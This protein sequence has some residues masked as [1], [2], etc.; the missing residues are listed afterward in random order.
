MKDPLALAIGLLLAALLGACEKDSGNTEPQAPRQNIEQVS[1]TKNNGSPVSGTV[2]ELPSN[3]CH[4]FGEGISIMNVAQAKELSGDF[5]GDG[6]T[7]EVLFLHL[8]DRP[9]FYEDVRIVDLSFG[10]EPTYPKEGSIGI[11][12]VL[13]GKDDKSCKKYIA[14]GDS[15]FSF[16]E[17]HNWWLQDDI[18]IDFIEKES[19]VFKYWK[20][21]INNLKYDALTLT[22][23][24]SGQVLI[25]WDGD[26]FK[27][28][29][30]K[31]YEP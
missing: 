9:Q 15:F 13:A 6:L 17:G 12:F 14:Y 11:A 10:A 29:A 30:D 3:K 27:L 25:Y 21:Q 26:T 4:E 19:D 5:N 24:S 23:P 16:D 2:A 31:N 20:E 1:A 22:M 18:P 28:E 7:D 8:I